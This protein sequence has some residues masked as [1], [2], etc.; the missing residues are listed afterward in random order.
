MLTRYAIAYRDASDEGC[1]VF[2]M[3]MWA[4]DEDHAWQK[5]HD[6]DDSEGWMVLSIRPVRVAV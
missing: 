3:G 1:P 2:M 4:Y 6:G 5:F